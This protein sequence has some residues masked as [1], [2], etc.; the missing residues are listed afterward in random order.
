LIYD[1]RVTV[2]INFA[3]IAVLLD[4]LPAAPGCGA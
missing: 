4:L 1:N 3:A 2:F